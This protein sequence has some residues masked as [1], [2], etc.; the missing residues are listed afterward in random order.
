MRADLGTFFHHHYGN[1]S[2]DLLE[3]DRCRK[4]GRPGSHNDHVE[5]H[6]LAGW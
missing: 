1:I 3:A 2:T 4:P 6:R 5:F